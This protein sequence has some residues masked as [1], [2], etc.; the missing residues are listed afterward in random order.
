MPQSTSTTPQQPTPT[1]APLPPVAAA[2]LQRLER[3]FATPA[4]RQQQ[5]APQ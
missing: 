5:A 4:P 3:A 1:C 2:A